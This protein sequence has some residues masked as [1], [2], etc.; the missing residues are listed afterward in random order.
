MVGDANIMLTR[1]RIICNYIIYAFGK[2]DIS[3]QEA[4]HNLGRGYMEAEYGTYEYDKEKGMET[5]HIKFWYR[6]A[7]FLLTSYI[8]SLSN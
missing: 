2:R 6:Q 1:L 5:Y 7:D 8:L 3:P 4:V